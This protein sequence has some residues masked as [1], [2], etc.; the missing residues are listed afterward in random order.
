MF[1]QNNQKGEQ[2]LTK[3]RHIFPQNVTHLEYDMY[4]IISTSIIHVYTSRIV[5][6]FN[7]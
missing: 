2:T 7:P 4:N 1:T 3:S 5:V 6:L